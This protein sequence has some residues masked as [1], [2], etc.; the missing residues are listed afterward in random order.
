MV[1]YE[2]INWIIQASIIGWLIGLPMVLHVDKD[3]WDTED[4]VDVMLLIGALMYGILALYML[5]MN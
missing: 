4:I 5:T 2:V 1:Y 3:N